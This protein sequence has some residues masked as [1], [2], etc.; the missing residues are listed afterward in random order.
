MTPIRRENWLSAPFH[1]GERNF[2]ACGWPKNSQLFMIVKSA[3]VRYEAQSTV[4][5]F[6]V[7]SVSFA[8]HRL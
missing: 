6:A 2:A 4:F 7:R 5:E 1:I 8:P 3:A